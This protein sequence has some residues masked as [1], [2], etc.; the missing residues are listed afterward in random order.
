MGLLTTPG[1][2]TTSFR[3]LAGSLVLLVIADQIY[4]IQNLDGTYVAGGPID[5]HLPALLSDLRG[6][7]PPSVDAPA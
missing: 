2:R 5:T 3:L 7:R 6:G 4:A 1:A